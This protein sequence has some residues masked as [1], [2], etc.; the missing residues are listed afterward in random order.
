M[1]EVKRKYLEQ[2]KQLT[3]TNTLYALQAK[4]AEIKISKLMSENLALKQEA[5][6]QKTTIDRLKEQLSTME[7][8]YRGKLDAYKEKLTTL[9]ET[10]QTLAK[11]TADWDKNADQTTI[12]NRTI[13]SIQEHVSEILPPEPTDDSTYS[14]IKT[15]VD[16]V[17]ES[18]ILKILPDKPK[19]S[20]YSVKYT[21]STR[22]HSITEYLDE[23]PSTHRIATPYS[24]T[25]LH[26]DHVKEPVT[27]NSGQKAEPRSMASSKKTTLAVK[28]EANR[29]T[30]KMTNEA[31]KDRQDKEKMR[32][33]PGLVRK[34]LEPLSHENMEGG[35]PK[36]TRRQIHPTFNSSNNGTSLLS[37][38]AKEASTLSFDDHVFDFSFHPERDLIAVGLIT[39]HVHCFNYG[40]NNTKVFDIKPHKKSCRG[41]EFSSD[42]SV[43]YSISKDKSLQA[44]DVETVQVTMKKAGAHEHPINTL[45]KI[46]D[47]MLGTGDDAGV[48][49]IWDVRKPEAVQT[50]SE[51]SDFISDMSWVD[52]KRQL[53]ATGG[54][55]YLSVWDIRKP[56]VA[57]MSDNLEDELLSV[58][59]NGRKAV[60]GSQE[61]ILNL[62]SYGYWGDITDRF[63]GHP[64][65]IDTIVKIDEDTVCTGS[66]DGI[67]RVVSILPNKL[68]GIIGDHGED[69]PIERIHLSHDK[70]Y[71][72]SC[73][74]DQS[75][76]LW[77]VQ[78][79][80]DEDDDE[81]EETEEDKD[82]EQEAVGESVT[83]AN[84]KG[85]SDSSDSDAPSAKKGKRTKPSKPAPS[86]KQKGGKNQL[87]GFFTDL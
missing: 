84:I 55:G 66:S 77:D 80:F 18:M 28:S 81:Q 46:G 13:A 9:V 51:H 10:A 32:K 86:K 75:V 14:F 47:H 45:V 87:S 64:N 72:G 11:L 39:G 26:S 58:E 56:N 22:L 2:N 20:K 38:M 83:V 35:P 36:R 43:L 33:R 16:H 37:A 65:S 29:S 57:A 60:V 76:R 40:V 30:P 41:L 52:T 59:V 79:L 50:Y 67:I 4:K 6:N 12:L 21:P 1:D 7:S 82:E 69:F 31:V 15:H 48:I 85:D 25:T 23:E 3:R 49:K 24:H 70:K 53:I 17:P 71:L 62:F 19:P 27:T 34:P 78:W 5:M 73:S 68:L 8:T 74:H 63:L 44:I 42:G 54:D 61:G